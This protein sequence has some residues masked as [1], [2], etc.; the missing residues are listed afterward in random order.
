MWVSPLRLND[1]TN[2]NDVVGAGMVEVRE[3]WTVDHAK[4]LFLVSKFAKA[5]ASAE[6]AE[7]WIRQIP[8]L[9]MLY[10]GVTA[11]VLDFDYAPASVL[12][13]QN[14]VSRRV[15]LNVTQEGKAAVDDLR[16]AGLINGLK[17]STEDFQPVTA[18]QVSLKGLQFIKQMDA[19]SCC[20]FVARSSCPHRVAVAFVLLTISPFPRSL[21]Q[22]LTAEVDNFVHT[23]AGYSAKRELLQVTFKTHDE[24]EEEGL[25]LLPPQ[26]EE[27]ED[28]GGGDDD[29]DD[30]EGIGV[31]IL[32]AKSGD[33]CRL[34]NVTDTEDVSYV[35]SPY[36]PACVRNPRE[37]KAFSSNE[38]RAHESATGTANIRD[39]LS[40]AIVLS[41][42]MTLVGEWI[43]FGANQI[44]ALNER[45]GYVPSALSR[46]WPCFFCFF[47]LGPGLSSPISTLLVAHRLFVLGRGVLLQGVGSLP[48]RVVHCNGG[49][50][51]HPYQVFR[52]TWTHPGV[53]LGL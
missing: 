45:L 44:V 14:G 18:Y 27:E 8:L 16:E 49:Q 3:F 38:H 34:S 36:L 51:S 15:W 11:Q 5:A 9:V 33:Y 53:H 25:D 42:V 10:E 31:F 46:W 35:S 26:G 22:E 12:I 41:D 28:G 30:D 40:E 17:L 32:K 39:E 21:S 24:I 13:S 37:Q 2:D 7:S 23:P 50:R 20:A 4:T 48:R 6:D 19:V 1:R 29:D 47:V 43:P 52:A